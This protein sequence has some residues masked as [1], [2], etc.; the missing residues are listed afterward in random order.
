MWCVSKIFDFL[1]S[2]YTLTT[3]H[4]RRD[5]FSVKTPGLLRAIVAYKSLALVFFPRL[6]RWL[7]NTDGVGEWG[8]RGVSNTAQDVPM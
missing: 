5:A 2:V 8:V 7:V 3:I 6:S 1:S 4:L